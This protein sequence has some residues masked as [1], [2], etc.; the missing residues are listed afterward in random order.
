MKDLI[1]FIAR[2]LV[3]D[4][5]QVVVRESA[6]RGSVQLRLQVAKEDMGRVIG[7]N[8]RV[9]NAMRT[10]LNVAATQTGKRASLD[11]DEPR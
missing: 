9:A 11:I 10:L 1:E 6:R 3:D 8:G 4:P 5:T 7:R 2:S